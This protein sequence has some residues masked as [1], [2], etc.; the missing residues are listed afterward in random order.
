MAFLFFFLSDHMVIITSGVFGAYI[1][2]R[3]ITMYAGGYV[4]EFTVIL[5]T[6]NGDL[7]DIQWTMILYWV[8]MILMAIGS[9]MA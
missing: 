3:G 4:N 7:A 9:I 8:L 5:A 6:N 1:F 2:I